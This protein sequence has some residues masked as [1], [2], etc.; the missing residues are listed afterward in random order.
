MSTVRRFAFLM[1]VLGAISATVGLTGTVRE[2]NDAAIGTAAAYDAA[3][4]TKSLE[5]DQFLGVEEFDSSPEAVCN[6]CFSLPCTVPGAECSVPENRCICKTCN[7][8]FNC[9][10]RGQS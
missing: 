10:K 3:L 9:F 7:S 4:L 8:Q 5:P 6:V 1:L 2:A